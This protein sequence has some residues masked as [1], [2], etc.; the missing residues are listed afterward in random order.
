M[1]IAK[2]FTILRDVRADGKANVELEREPLRLV[3]MIDEQAF[4][5]YGNAVIHGETG[6]I[7]TRM[8]DWNWDNGRLRYFT[9]TAK[10]ANLLIIYA[11]HDDLRTKFCIECGASAVNGCTHQP[12]PSA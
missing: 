1:L 4:T 7:E 5:D 12:K 6:Y 10:T 11:D 3:T 2:D 8:H 9:R